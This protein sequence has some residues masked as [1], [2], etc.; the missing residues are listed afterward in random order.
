MP[1][2]RSYKRSRDLKYYITNYLQRSGF[3]G[4]Q[5]KETIKVLIETHQNIWDI[6]TTLGKINIFSSLSDS[7]AEAFLDN[8]DSGNDELITSLLNNS[9]QYRDCGFDPICKWFVKLHEL[10]PKVGYNIWK[11]LDKSTRSFYRKLYPKR[12]CLSLIKILKPNDTLPLNIS[13]VYPTILDMQFGKP[14]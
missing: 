10:T 13:D 3:D 4:R 14:C 8:D 9:Y 11:G 1:K 6:R 12:K 2:N 5:I 7:K